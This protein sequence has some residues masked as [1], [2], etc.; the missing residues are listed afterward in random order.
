MS[1][2]DRIEQLE[3]AKIAKRAVI[4]KGGTGDATSIG[5]IPVNI[6]GIL[7]TGDVISYSSSPVEFTATTPTPPEYTAYPCFKP[8]ST[9]VVSFNLVG[10]AGSG[11]L[12]TGNRNY[13][14]PIRICRA[15]TPSNILI[16]VS[17]AVASSSVHI[18]LYASN[19]DGWPSGSPITSSA[20]L[21]CATTGDKTHAYS[22]NLLTRQYWLAV[23]TSAT[24]PNLRN[25]PATAV[26]TL[27]LTTSGTLYSYLMD[28][29][30][31]FGTWRNFTTTPA[32]SSMLT[33]GAPPAVFITA[34]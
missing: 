10:D 4:T 12:L 26:R 20:N 1:R 34:A 24:A 11:A 19:A 30:A 2:F 6:P 9:S 16:R 32:T 18:A 17:T 25:W 13:Y 15:F 23:Q 3:I 7:T 31:L 27:G 33:T 8:F 14:M 28:T 21:S 5:G 22:G 29:P